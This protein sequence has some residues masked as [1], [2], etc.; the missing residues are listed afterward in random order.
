MPAATEPAVVARTRSVPKNVLIVGVGGQ[1]VIMVSKVLA[2][3]CQ[4]QGFE[5][6]QSEVH[7]MAKRGGSVFSHVRFGE[8]VYSPVI[9]RGKVDVLVAL[10]WAEGLRWL[11]YLNQRRGTFIADTQHIIPPFAC[12]NR[13]RGAHSAYVCES[14]S[15]VME[16]VPN[17]F[18]LDA[19]GMATE[20][21]VPRAANT[22]LLG[23][24][25]A[26][27]DFSAADWQSVISQLVPPKTVE[28]NLQAF[29]QGRDWALHFD[30][31]SVKS[32]CVGL[33][34][35][36]AGNLDNVADLSRVEI[37]EAW[38][39]GCDICVKFCPERCLQL[40][41]RQVVEMVHAERCTG[42]RMCE[43]LCP[44]FAIAVHTPRLPYPATVRDNNELR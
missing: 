40:N 11:P 21:G 32:A 27:L 19:V 10:E 5:V 34:R 2:V 25:S 13:N 20:L 30:R 9:P 4:E 38:C 44:D 14:V 1:G 23:I 7:G 33:L 43:W 15:E 29:A 26:A 28:A 12:R 16:Q 8:Q 35:N 6:K 22:V 36:A 17:S 37:T 18:A 39:K 41:A 24:L 42:C 3:L 31:E